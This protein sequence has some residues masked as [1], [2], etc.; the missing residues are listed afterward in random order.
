MNEIATRL[1]RVVPAAAGLKEKRG[2]QA[3][4]EEGAWHGLPCM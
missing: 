2:A 3:P 1:V 4:R